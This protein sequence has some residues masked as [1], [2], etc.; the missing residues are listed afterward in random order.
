M[1]NAL[2]FTVKKKWVLCVKNFNNNSAGHSG[3]DMYDIRAG[4]SPFAIYKM[5]ADMEKAGR[6]G[7]PPKFGL[8]G[9]EVIYSYH[10]VEYEQMTDDRKKFGHG[11]QTSEKFVKYPIGTVYTRGELKTVAQIMEKKYFASLPPEVQN[12]FINFIIGVVANRKKLSETER[13][14]KIV[15]IPGD[16]NY[17]TFFEEFEKGGKVKPFKF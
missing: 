9:R 16:K 12:S 3:I 13:E 8:D 11:N 6:N 17:I 10:V 4:K 5:V 1:K 7:P 2:K 14:K 15:M